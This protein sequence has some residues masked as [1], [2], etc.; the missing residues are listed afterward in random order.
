M[1]LSE[2]QTAIL[3]YLRTKKD[4]EQF[5]SPTEIAL[6]IFGVS[7]P[8]RNKDAD[9]DAVKAERKAFREAFTLSVDQITQLSELGLI[10]RHLFGGCRLIGTCSPDESS[11]SFPRLVVVDRWLSH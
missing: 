11:A 4:P 6:E 5:T 3:D 8:G 10:E 1:E 2:T 7:R 9:M